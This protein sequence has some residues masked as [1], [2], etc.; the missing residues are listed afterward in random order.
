MVRSFVRRHLALLLVVCGG[1]IGPIDCSFDFPSP[2]DDLATPTPRDMRAARVADCVDFPS[3]VGVVVGIGTTV[4]CR[5]ACPD[6]T[7]TCVSDGHGG[8]IWT[9]CSEC[10][11]DG[12]ASD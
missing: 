12:G 6:S 8:A 7:R 5:G 9:S 3:G 10:P 1:C 4:A 2:P 11:D